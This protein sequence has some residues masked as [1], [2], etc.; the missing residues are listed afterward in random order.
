MNGDTETLIALVSSLLPQYTYSQDVILDALIQCNGDVEGAV[1]V[2]QSKTPTKKRNHSSLDSWL[3]RPVKKISTRKDSP[4]SSSTI[5][6][7]TTVASSSVNL[8]SVLR[9]PPSDT[10]SKPSRLPTLTLSTP[11]LVAKHTPCTLHL[12]VL[13][14]ELAC[15]LFY[16]MLD[17]SKKWKRNKW[18]IAD[19]VVES[20]HLTSFYVR[21]TDKDES[22]QET[23]QYWCVITT[24][25]CYV[26]DISVGTMGEQSTL[27][28]N[29]HRKWKKLARLWNELLIKK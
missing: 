23:A 14:Q 16:T 17:A 11:A 3:N 13:P 9:Q 7:P 20:P 22:W 19:R 2:L 21:K 1:E 8:L 15:K 25:D 28:L 5:K 10:P 29:F 27:H 24:L 4:A 6:P 18:W 26:I 12:S